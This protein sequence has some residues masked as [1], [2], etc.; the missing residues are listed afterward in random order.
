MNNSKITVSAPGKLMLFGEH[1]VVYGR[2]CIVTAVKARI[3]VKIEKLEYP[4]LII[5]A[6]DV[7]IT[8]YKKDIGKLGWGKVPGGV[9][10]IE[11][12]VRNFNNKY[13]LSSG[14]K[15]TT[16]SGFSSKFGFGSSSA[17]TVAVIKALS[18]LFRIKL[19]NKELFDLSYKTVLGVQGVG[20]GFDLA[21][22]IWGGTLYFVK[23]GE[24]IIS[25]K[26]GSLPLTIGYTG[27]K[28]DTTTLVRGVASIYKTKKEIVEKIFEVM[29]VVV[30]SAK[31]ALSR[32]DYRELGVLMNL[33]QGLLDSLGVSTAK[34]S[35]LIT[36]SR[37]AGAYGAKLSGAGGGDCMIALADKKYG[38]KVRK[39]IRFAG[40]IILNVKTGEEGVRIEK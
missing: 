4:E 23:G 29:G 26:I 14:L 25:L 15:I 12:A 19:S 2:P 21:A 36:A 8:G 35:D 34:L 33:N 40:G 18:E 28:A 13:N 3:T 1:A 9:I 10:F 17:V 31:K 11:F 7:G 39:A 20:S 27:V 5:N 38:G 30:E 32:S 6:P 22:A 37:G 16:K 24:K